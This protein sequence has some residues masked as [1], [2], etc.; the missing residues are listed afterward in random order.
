MRQRFT[1]LTVLLIITFMAIGFYT[2]HALKR[3]ETNNTTENHV[4]QL[5]SLM[6]Q[7][8][9]NEKDFLARES[10]NPDFHAT[11]KSKYISKFEYNYNKAIHIT[12]DLYKSYFIKSEH[13][14]QKID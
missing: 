11:G 12:S 6:L 10:T 7:L 5:E 9:R 4:Y 8:R 2:Y 1:I 3:I 13:M 14:E